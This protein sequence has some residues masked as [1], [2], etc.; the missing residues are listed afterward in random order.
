MNFKH[1]RLLWQVL[2]S[3]AGRLCPEYKQRCSYEWGIQDAPFEVSFLAITK[4]LSK[5]ELDSL[6]FRCAAADCGQ[7]ASSHCSRCQVYTSK[8]AILPRVGA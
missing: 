7:P 4:V 8:G 3:N 6:H 1:S 2:M 5:A